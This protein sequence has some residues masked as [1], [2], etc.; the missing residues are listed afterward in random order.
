MKF[1][2]LRLAFASLT[3]VFA[4][5][6]AADPSDSNAQSDESDLSKAKPCPTAPASDAGAPATDA[7]PSVDS[8]IVG[9]YIGQ[10]DTAEL[11]IGANGTYS[12]M[13]YCPPQ[14]VCPMVF[15][16]YEKGTWSAAAGAPG[17]RQKVV[18]LTPTTP[19]A[20]PEPA[21]TYGWTFKGA[22]VEADGEVAY[23]PVGSCFTNA[24]CASG[25][26]GPVLDFAQCPANTSDC[27]ALCQSATP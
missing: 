12:I 19:E 25:S 24:Q 16:V 3:A 15:S 17:T 27:L 22:L 6:C 7:G 13:N 21:R 10:N 23:R 11:Q 14:Q 26:C 4:V 5:A 18:T 20:N 8:K 2:A 9:T 1:L